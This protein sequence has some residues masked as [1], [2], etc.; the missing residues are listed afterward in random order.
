VRRSSAHD[1]RD[2]WLG[3]GLRHLAA[4]AAI[5]SEGTFSSAALSLGYVQSAVSG[6]LATLERL[7]GTRLVERT[8][9]PGPQRLTE[10]GELLLAHSRDIVGEL[11]AARRRLASSAEPGTNG[12]RLCLA[13]GLPDRL[14]GP[15]LSSVLPRSGL[16]L[17][18]VDTL[19]PDRIVDALLDD[20]ADLVLTPWPV[21]HDA[22]ATTELNRQALVAVVRADSVLARRRRAPTLR[23]LTRMP[24]VVWR[25]GQAP[26]RLER[27]LAPLSLRPNVVARADSSDTVTSL[28]RMGLGAAV[29]PRGAVG[30]EPGLV[31]LE[32]DEQPLVRVIRLAWLRS[33]SGD[34]TL[35]SLID[36][37]CRLR[38]LPPEQAARVREAAAD[39]R[40]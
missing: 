9:G 2:P 25:E 12:L 36:L 19:G 4:L 10:A 18:R 24:L 14:I 35:R 23:A 27:E 31:V 11:E 39:S 20:E 7:T 28:V 8:R 32:L 30:S 13:S 38:R 16:E 17:E 6:Q 15:L 26:S 21:E 29:L 37:G 40:S 22:V 1:R 34:P 33:R 5:E 3:I